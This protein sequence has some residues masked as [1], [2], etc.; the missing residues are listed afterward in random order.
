[1]PSKC[2][3]KERRCG[4]SNCSSVDVAMSGRRCVFLCESKSTLFD[5]LKIDAFRIIKITYNRTAQPRCYHSF[6]DLGEEV[7]LTLLWQ[8]GDS[9]SATVCFV[10]ILSICS[11]LLKYGA[12]H[13][14]CVRTRVC[15]RGRHG[16]TTTTCVQTHTSF[17]TVSVTW[18]C[19]PFGLG[20]MVKLWTLITVFTFIF[21]LNLAIMERGVTFPNHACGVRPITMHCVNWPIRA[22]CACWREGL[23]R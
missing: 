21:K 20:L 22:D 19:S 1:M 2:S 5:L 12:L 10:I 23:C 6:V 15:E 7:I 16:H 11:W 14:V 3:R 13:V 17:I 18:L 8:S 4:F 9:E